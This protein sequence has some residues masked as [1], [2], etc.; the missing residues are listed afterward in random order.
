MVRVMAILL[1]RTITLLVIS[2]VKSGKIITVKVS[3]HRYGNGGGIMAHG[4]VD[5]PGVGG[6][7]IEDAGEAWGP[8][9]KMRLDKLVR[10]SA[11]INLVRPL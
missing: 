4:R 1:K 7:Q 2:L 8:S 10:K 9:R 11:V 3:L 6:Q 5:L